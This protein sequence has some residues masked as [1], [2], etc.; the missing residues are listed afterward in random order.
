[1]ARPGRAW[2]GAA[3]QGEARHGMARQGKAKQSKVLDVIANGIGLLTSADS[4]GNK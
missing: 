1:M 3:W 2:H 4:D